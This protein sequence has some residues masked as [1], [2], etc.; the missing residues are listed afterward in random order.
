MLANDETSKPIQRLA[1]M[2]PYLF[3]YLGYFSLIAA[4][5]QFIIFDV[6]QY[7][8][9]GWINRN[10]ILKPGFGSDQY[11]LV[12]LV[13]HPRNTLICDVV[14]ANELPWKNKLLAQLQHYKKRAPFFNDTQ[15]LV[16]T[17]LE[18]DTDS[19]VEL[20]IHCLETV[21]RALQ[22]PLAVRRLDQQA[23][24]FQS[25]AS[26]VRDAGEWALRLSI[27]RQASTYL[28]PPGGREIFDAEKFREH[29]VHLCFVQNRLTEYSQKNSQFI[30]GLSIID[31]LMFNGIDGTRERVMDYEMVRA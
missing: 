17:A 18:F 22:L 28:N 4:S 14:I 16:A 27:Q 31:S 10:R 5:D 15:E 8:R 9:H 23:P 30:G 25:L 24:S 3:P 1:I 12:P 6:V 21:C 29:G 7:I 26:S 20:N 19:L 11:V 2:Q 13:K